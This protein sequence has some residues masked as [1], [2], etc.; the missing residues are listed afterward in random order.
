MKEENL[1][2]IDFNMGRLSPEDHQQLQAEYMKEASEVLDQ[3]EQSA[4]GQ[5][6]ISA[7]IE[8]EVQKIRKKHLP[9]RTTDSSQQE[10]SAAQ[11][12]SP[13]TALPEE[14]P[15]DVSVEHLSDEEEATT[16]TQCGKVN[17]E[18]AKFCIE[19][20]A[21]LKNVQ[22]ESCGALSKIGSKFCAQCGHE[23]I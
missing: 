17:D 15:A 3:L 19:C 18:N 12:S 13:H 11:E 6:K 10:Q 16:C 2:N 7:Q 20:G 21:S 8:Q 22:C 1:V 9:S 4:N 5:E 23:L 14:M